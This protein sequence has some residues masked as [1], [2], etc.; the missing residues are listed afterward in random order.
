MKGKRKGK[1]KGKDEE[2]D[3]DESRMERR[4]QGADRVGDQQEN[5]KGTEKPSLQELHLLAHINL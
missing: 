3:K 2:K 4:I 5:R 1:G